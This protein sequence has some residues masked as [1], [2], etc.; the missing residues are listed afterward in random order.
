MKINP[1]PGTSMANVALSATQTPTQEPA[2]MRSIKMNTNR[3]VNRFGDPVVEEKEEAPI[4]AAKA[5]TTP[6]E[7]VAEKPQEIGISDTDVQTKPV[8]EVIQQVSPQVAALA[9]EKRALQVMKREIAEE[10][11]KL[12]KPP[13]G[14]YVTSDFL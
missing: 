14:D 8:P 13:E 10:K 9:K 3:T 4:E 1:I 12:S 2:T 6:T 7:P 11:A 5:E